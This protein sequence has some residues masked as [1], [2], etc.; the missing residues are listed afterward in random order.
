[1]YVIT[2]RLAELFAAWR[3]EIVSAPLPP[4]PERSVAL[5]AIERGR[6]DRVDAPPDGAP[7]RSGIAAARGTA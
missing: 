5:R 6:E 3:A 1:M 7:T 4:L 2:D